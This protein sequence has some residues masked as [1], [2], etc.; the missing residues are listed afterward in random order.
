MHF[1]VTD[2]PQPHSFA[3]VIIFSYAYQLLYRVYA[4]YS[5]TDHLLSNYPFLLKFGSGLPT[6]D[7]PI[8]FSSG[9][10]RDIF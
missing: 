7:G 1:P 5:G 6:K 10:R 4:V 2:L 8:L 3:F 9:L